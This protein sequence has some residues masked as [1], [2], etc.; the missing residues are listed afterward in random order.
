MDQ[1]HLLRLIPGLFGCNLLFRLGLSEAREE[2]TDIVL[3]CRE[4]R[5]VG[6][7]RQGRSYG[8]VGKLVGDTGQGGEGTEIRKGGKK[9]RGVEDRQ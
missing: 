2:Y 5:T 1:P 7:K 8:Q 4:T 9:A 3:Y 6:M